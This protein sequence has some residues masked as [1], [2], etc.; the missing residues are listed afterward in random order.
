[1]LGEEHPETLTNVLRLGMVYRQEG[2]YA[3]AEPL[4]ITALEASQR[5]RGPEH[6]DTLAAMAALAI[7]YQEQGKYSEAEPLLT[8]ALETSRR[9]LGPAHA[10]TRSCAVSLAK[11][12]LA[13][14]KYP[15]AETLLRESLNAKDSEGPYSWPPFERRSLL[16]LSLME[17]SKF[18]EAEPL[19]LA[20]YRGLLQRKSTLPV[21]VSVEQ[22]GAGIVQLYTR[23]GKADQAAQWRREVQAAGL[24]TSGSR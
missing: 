16:G 12:R 19:L 8:K 23:W 7:L 4:H 2:K 13:Q 20:G 18:A 11:L 17:Q 1:M 21:A 5:V 15:E 14:Q 9:V 24:G 10:T 6:A 3:E 22:A